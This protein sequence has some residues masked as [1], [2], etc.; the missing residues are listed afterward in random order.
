MNVDIKTLEQI[1]TFTAKAKKKGLNI[2]L[3]IWGEGGVGKTTTVKRFARDNNYDIEMLHLANQSPEILLGLEHKDEK[4]KVTELFPPK[5]LAR[6]MNSTKPCI[7]FLDELNRAPKY[8]IQALFSFINEGHLHTHHIK[9]DDIVIVAGN[10]DSSDYDVTSFDDR[11]FTSRFCHLYLEP[12]INEVESYFRTNKCS[13]ALLELLKDRPDIAQTTCPTKIKVE[14]TNR[15][16]EKVGLALNMMNEDELRS[17]AS[18]LFSGMIGS[19][20][21]HTLIKYALESIKLPDVKKILNGDLSAVQNNRNRMDVI[22]ATN[23]ALAQAYSKYLNKGK[24]DNVEKTY[25]NIARYME[26]VPED[27]AVAFLT[28]LRNEAYKI[29]FPHIMGA[30]SKIGCKDDGTENPEAVERFL[31]NGQLAAKANETPEAAK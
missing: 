12:T 5:W 15:M 3:F 24:L 14:S 8:V 27:A 16:L 13:G 28:E 25:I 17:F 29:E 19:D 30:L 31:T 11:A 21:S 26:A 6:G 9:P 22:S 18:P 10:P 23:T 2:P 7:Y 4:N 20:L 1:L